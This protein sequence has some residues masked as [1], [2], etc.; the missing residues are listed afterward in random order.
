MMLWW[1][2]SK[3]Q[4]IWMMCPPGDKGTTDFTHLDMVILSIEEEVEEE[5]EE[6]ESGFRKGRWK[7]PMEVLVE[8]RVEI[9]MRDHNNKLLQ[10]DLIQLDR[11]M[12]GLYP[13]LLRE[14]MMQRDSRQHNCLPQLPLLP[15]RKDYLLTGAVKVLQEKEVISKFNWLEV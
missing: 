12:S 4:N 14:E 15:Q 13:L 6:E 10:I 7:D 1:N 3:Q 11:M 8:E 5:V 2:L 9:T